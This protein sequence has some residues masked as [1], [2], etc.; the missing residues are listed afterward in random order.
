MPTILDPAC[1]DQL[2]A[3]IRRLEPDLKPQWGR[4]NASQ[5]ICH[6][7][8]QLRVALGE[9][10]VRD[11]S[12]FFSRGPLKALVLYAPL[13]TP[14]GKIQTADEMLDTQATTWDEDIARL[15]KL[16][17]RFVATDPG[18]TLHPMFGQL[19]HRQW[20]ILAAKHMAHH[21]DQFGV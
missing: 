4:M 2:L 7:G 5:M 10:P 13:P 9:K 19:N 3:R 17:E 6:L 21:L 14:K 8:D 1:R 15:E 18:R 12:N 16:V 20:G 11:I